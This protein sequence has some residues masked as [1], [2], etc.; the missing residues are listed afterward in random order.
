MREPWDAVTPVRA[1][2]SWH[3]RVANRPLE[4]AARRI[5]IM[6]SVAALIVGSV[7]VVIVVGKDGVGVARAALSQSLFQSV[8]TAA[9]QAEAKKLLSIKDPVLKTGV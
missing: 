5:R 2:E 4:V 8:A 9:E 1:G 7:F 3:Q 6:A